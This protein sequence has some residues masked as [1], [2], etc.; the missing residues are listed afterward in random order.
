MTLRIHIP[1]PGILVPLYPPRMEASLTPPR[2]YHKTILLA[3]DDPTT[4]TLL[5]KLLE[6]SGYRVLPAGDGEEALRICREHEAEIDLLVIDVIMPKM[7]GT[8]LAK[9]VHAF[10]PNLPILFISGVLAEEIV[11]SQ[12]P[13]R[14]EAY[15]PKPITTEQLLG[16]TRRLLAPHSA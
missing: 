1:F 7:S 5:K 9:H 3:D 12:Q 6:R 10:R 2:V 15:L 4:V 8:A 16:M 14:V 11:L 13:R